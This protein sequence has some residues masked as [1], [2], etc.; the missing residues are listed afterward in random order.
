MDS[1]CA[2]L[3]YC[4]QPEI[5][6]TFIS[7]ILYSVSCDAIMTLLMV[8]QGITLKMT[9]DG[10]CLVARILHGGMIH[11]QG[12]LH[13]GDELREVNGY[14]VVGQSVETLQLLLVCL[15]LTYVIS[16]A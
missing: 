15:Y 16:K 1:V 2:G 12:T 7:V 6:I 9:D 8:C 14:T 10:R 5:Y 13:V 3:C 11:R 4:K